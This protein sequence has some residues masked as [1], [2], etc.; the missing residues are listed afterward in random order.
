[1]DLGIEG[2]N[3]TLNV[4]TKNNLKFIGV[5]NNKYTLNYIIIEK[6]GI[7]LGFIGYSNSDI[8]YPIP[9]W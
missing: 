4:L 9:L 6:R 3:E 2:F 7:K 8:K 5:S 1:M